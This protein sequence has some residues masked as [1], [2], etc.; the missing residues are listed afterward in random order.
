MVAGL[1]G[2]VAVGVGL[3]R[4]SAK[5]RE[6][7]FARASGV[8][9]IY[10]IDPALRR[11]DEQFAFGTEALDEGRRRDSGLPGCHL[12]GEPCRAGPRQNGVGCIEQVIIGVHSGTRHAVSK[13]LFPNSANALVCPQMLR[14]AHDVAAGRGS[15][16]TDALGL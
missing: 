15:S 16:H 5:R 7:R 1:V 6:D 12:E 13:S 11:R 10:C 4:Q 9:E 14:C 2:I 3:D 8:V